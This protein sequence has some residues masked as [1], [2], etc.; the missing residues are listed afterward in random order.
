MGRPISSYTSRV[1]LPELKTRSAG[2]VHSVSVS[3][4]ARGGRSAAARVGKRK[5]EAPD[6][7][8][9]YEAGG[10][11]RASLCCESELWS[12]DHAVPLSELS[13]LGREDARAGESVVGGR[14]GEA[15]RGQHRKET[16]R[17][18]FKTKFKPGVRQR[19]EVCRLSSLARADRTA[20]G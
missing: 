4:S 12:I 17:K 7:P 11:P 9:V 10:S 16:G 5:T 14:E 20:G 19:P 18:N 6:E 13:S 3:P 1:T 8:K 2:G 15:Q